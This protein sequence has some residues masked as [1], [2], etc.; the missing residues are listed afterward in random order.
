MGCRKRELAVD[1]LR[2]AAV[3]DGPGHY[4]VTVDSAGSLPGRGA[5]LHPDRQCLEA[6][7]RRRAFARALRITGSPEISAVVEYVEAIRAPDRHGL[8]NR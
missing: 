3:L 1:L 4:A 5:W 7:I 8:E 6:A 2:L